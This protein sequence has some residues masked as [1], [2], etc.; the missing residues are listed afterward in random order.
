IGEGKVICD[1][2]LEV[3]MRIR[4]DGIIFN[5]EKSICDLNWG[6]IMMKNTIRNVGIN[7][8]IGNFVV[9]FNFDKKLGGCVCCGIENKIVVVV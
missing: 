7:A 4:S 9:L 6:S 2:I 5:K 1:K 3:E 8:V